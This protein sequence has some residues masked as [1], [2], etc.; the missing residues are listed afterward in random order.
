MAG[1]A[2]A[3][4]W[5]EPRDTW[6]PS[7][8]CFLSAANCS[9]HCQTSPQQDLGIGEGIY[10]KYPREAPPLWQPNVFCFQIGRLQREDPGM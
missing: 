4:K 3:K 10:P 5:A 7:A 2:K 8:A 6:H 9:K 1:A